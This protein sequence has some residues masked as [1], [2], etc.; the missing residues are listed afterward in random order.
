MLLSL[1]LCA[2]SY[3]YPQKYRVFL[4]PQII[5]SSYLFKEGSRYVLEKLDGLNDLIKRTR[6]KF[7]SSNLKIVHTG[8]SPLPANPWVGSRRK[9][10]SSVVFSHRMMVSSSVVGP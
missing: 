8:I 4:Y 2:L 9:K 5:F 3:R 1:I 10:N 7:N 6:M